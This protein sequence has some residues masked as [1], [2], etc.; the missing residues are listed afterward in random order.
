MTAAAR[1]IGSI[2]ALA[3]LIEAFSLRAAEYDR[4]ARIPADNLKDAA[5]AGLFALT[6]PQ[7]FGGQGAGLAE[8][9][10]TARRLA[11]ADPATTLIVAMTWIQHAN[12]A[13]ERRWPDS[14]HRKVARDAVER[15]GLIN[16]LRVEPALGSPHRGGLPD[17]LARRTS[18][19]WS[20]TGQKIYS[21]GA[22]A[23]HW[24][25]VYARTDDA[26]P[27]VGYFLVPAQAKG[28]RIE[29]TWDHLGMR[30]TRSDDVFL[31]DVRLPASHAVDVRAPED[32]LVAPPVQLAWHALATSAIY[33]GVAEAARNWLVGFL[34][35]RAPSN[36]GRPLAKVERIVTAVGE[37]ESLLRTAAT[38]LDDAT[39]KVDRAPDSLRPEDAPMVK[40]VVTESAISAVQK[41]VALVGNPALSRSNPLER[42]LR[43]VMCARVHSPQGDSILQALGSA[44][45]KPV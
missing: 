16:A 29:Q 36:L 23:L 11:A 41:A 19:G 28:I 31:Q 26:S 38:L 40:H 3:S 8:V 1:R 18:D 10:T 17:T 43:D 5:D 13:R 37:I 34:H 42:H 4:T 24:F 12:I 30:A 6:V 20:I 22:L 9:A 32:W 15:R 27:R 44:A 7:Q 39:L 45:L 25:S 2:N 33:L 14:I 21:T 35:T